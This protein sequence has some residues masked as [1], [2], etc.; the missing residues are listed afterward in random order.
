MRTVHHIFVAFIAC[1]ARCNVQVEDPV[2]EAKK[3]VGA[4]MDLTD[5]VQ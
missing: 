4:L 5:L 3:E 1:R 2:A